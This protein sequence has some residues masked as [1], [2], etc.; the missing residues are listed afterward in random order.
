MADLANSN[1][2]ERWKKMKKALKAR[3]TAIVIGTGAAAIL[4]VLLFSFGLGLFCS[5]SLVNVYAV[6]EQS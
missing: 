3:K 6:G 4:S 5:N 1:R 2:S